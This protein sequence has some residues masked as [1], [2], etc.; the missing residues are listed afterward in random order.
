[1]FPWGRSHTHWEILGWRGQLYKSPCSDPASSINILCA[2]MMLVCLDRVL[3][4]LRALSPPRV[5]YGCLL[6]WLHDGLQLFLLFTQADIFRSDF[7]SFFPLITFFIHFRS[8]HRPAALSYTLNLSSWCSSELV[9]LHCFPGWAAT[10][11]GSSIICDNV[12][13]L[14]VLCFLR[15]GF[16]W[17][18]WA[19]THHR[20]R[21]LNPKP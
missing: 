11:H 13:I 14:F 15:D 18:L 17:S 4:R 3:L 16:L 2:H 5:I 7:C 6:F 20:P 1:M 19:F 10:V 21:P 8:P 12:L 9:F